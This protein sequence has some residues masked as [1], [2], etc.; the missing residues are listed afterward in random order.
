LGTGNAPR[1]ARSLRLVALRDGDGATALWMPWRSGQGV[2]EGVL[3]GHLLV[4][5]GR[6]LWAQALVRGEHP[7][8]LRVVQEVLLYGLPFVC[9]RVATISPGLSGSQPISSSSS[10]LV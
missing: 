10:F 9:Y 5:H 2:G 6:A 7:T 8:L 1:A 4:F 3:Q